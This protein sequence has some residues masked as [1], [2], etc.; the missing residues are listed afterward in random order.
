MRRVD[1][2]VEI[3]NCQA[4]PTHGESRIMGHSLAI[5]SY[6]TLNRCRAALAHESLRAQIEIISFDIECAAAG[7]RRFAHAER[8]LQGI[9]NA[10]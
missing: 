10:L 7:Q 8:D 4:D 3:A 6:R 2:G 5:Q 1:H 9:G